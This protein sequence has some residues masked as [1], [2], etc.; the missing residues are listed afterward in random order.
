[1]DLE[2]KRPSGPVSVP[3]ET[4]THGRFLIGAI[5]IYGAFCSCGFAKELLILPICAT[6]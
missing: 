5:L 6:I 1:M 3:A 4:A 2:S